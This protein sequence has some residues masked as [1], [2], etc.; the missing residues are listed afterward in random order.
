MIYIVISFKNLSDRCHFCFW[1][2]LTD[3]KE[4]VHFAII[5]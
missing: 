3:K 4:E 1:C 2:H 5:K